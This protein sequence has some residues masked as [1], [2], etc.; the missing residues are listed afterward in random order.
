M[1]Y[2][3]SFVSRIILCAA[4]FGACVEQGGVDSSNYVAIKFTFTPET[5]GRDLVRAF[6]PELLASL[7][8]G[9]S[10]REWN[11][12]GSA[13]QFPSQ[14]DC[15]RTMANAYHT[16]L[17]SDENVDWGTCL[18]AAARI[19]LPPAGRTVGQIIEQLAPRLA[20]HLYGDGLD[21]SPAY[22][23]SFCNANTYCES[24]VRTA[25][26]RCLGK[27]RDA[28]WGQCAGRILM[29]PPLYSGDLSQCSVPGFEPTVWNDGGEVQIKNNCYNYAT[30]TRTDTVAVPGRAAGRGDGT[31]WLDSIQ[32]FD[33][34]LADGHIEVGRNAP[35]P[36]GLTKIGAS[37]FRTAI[38]Y[39]GFHFV[40]QNRDGQWSDKFGEG[41]ARLL[42]DDPELEAGDQDDIRYYCV[43]SREA[44][45][46]GQARIN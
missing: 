11:F 3:Y 30:N 9:P 7:Y 45:G 8:L 13:T 21:T 28:F 25:Y 41:A 31:S 17:A 32:F 6:L 43:C 29:D 34:V 15:A 35:C 42:G 1:T 46:K 38:L 19:S 20:E 27:K 39:F 2:L 22:G 36:V 4:L 33:A 16:C 23:Q 24:Q 26:T 12:C 14:R 44:E 5:R 37:A 18:G 40:R 10:A